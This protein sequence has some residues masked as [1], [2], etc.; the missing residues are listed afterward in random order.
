M[1]ETEAGRAKLFNEIE[2]TEKRIYDLELIGALFPKDYNEKLEES[3][4]DA[5]S[6]DS[7]IS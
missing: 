1:T 6:D 4:S 3:D 5:L 7:L 2:L